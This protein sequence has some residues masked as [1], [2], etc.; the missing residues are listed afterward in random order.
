MNLIVVMN[1]HCPKLAGAPLGRL[2]I[3]VPVDSFRLLFAY[4]GVYV[5]GTG[6]LE[7]GGGSVQGL[8]REYPGAR[9]DD[10]VAAHRCQVSALP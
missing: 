4:T 5:P 8:Q 3:S 10:A 2:R 6:E 7:A 1:R 9:G